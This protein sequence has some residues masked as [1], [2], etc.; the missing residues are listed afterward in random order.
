MQLHF[1]FYLLHF[2]NSRMEIVTRYS[3]FYLDP[4]GSIILSAKKT[5]LLCAPD[6]H[7]FYY[8]SGTVFCIN[9]LMKTKQLIIP[10]A[11]VVLVILG[12][13][14][15]RQTPAPDRPIDTTIID[16]ADIETTVADETAM[17]TDVTAPREP[18]IPECVIKEETPVMT[19]TA[20]APPKMID[21]LRSESAAGRDLAWAT[22]RRS[23]MYALIR[24]NPREA[25]AGALSPRQYALL[26]ENL[27][28]LVEMPVAA[29]GFYGVLAICSHGA[30]EEHINICQIEYEVI[31]D[32]GTE[33]AKG[34]KA[35]IYG[36][37]HQRTTE[38]NASL[39][40][41]VMD[42]HI[43]LYEND[44]VI[45]DDGEGFPGGRYAVY[46]RGQQWSTDDPDEAL[47]IKTR[48]TA[49]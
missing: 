17:P 24:E 13:F 10:A 7:S 41:V 38:E 28:A 46:Y 8:T 22:A 36:E 16:P 30:D 9:C 12:L 27:Q 49:R 47:A 43:A 1:A 45:I 34:Y 20:E 11:L 32:F 48:L 40:G 18:L 3:P 5:Y 31:T 4:I 39:Y 35:S 15:L 25:L 44:V 14:F 26:P 6:S 21:A 19:E 37:R 2:A 33:T 29:E 23:V 42:G